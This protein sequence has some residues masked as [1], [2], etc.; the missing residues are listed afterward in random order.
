MND[1]KQPDSAYRSPTHTANK[2]KVI[3]KMAEA[4]KEEFSLF[5]SLSDDNGRKYMTESDLMQAFGVGAGSE[6]VRVIG[7]PIQIVSVSGTRHEVHRL[8]LYGFDMSGVGVANQ[9]L[10]ADVL[11]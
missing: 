2:A 11:A 7:L 3:A 6:M 4:L 8:E 9:K 1:R 5:A 10:H